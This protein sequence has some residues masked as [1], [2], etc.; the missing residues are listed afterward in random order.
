MPDTQTTRS[1]PFRARLYFDGQCPLCS[2]WAKRFQSR[3]ASK[4]V[5]LL[6]FPDDA[7]PEEMLLV[8]SHG[9]PC[10]GADAALEL[11]RL[12]PWL[13]PLHTASRLPGAKPVLRRLYRFIAARR[14]CHGAGCRISTRPAPRKS[15]ALLIGLIGL[16][17][18]VGGTLQPWQWMW[19][20]AAAMW[21]G[22][23]F[24]MLELAPAR[25][26]P[27]FFLWPG[28]DTAAFTYDPAA[29]R[30]ARPLYEPLLFL[31][32]GLLLIPLALSQT[33]PVVTGWLGFAAMLAL[34][35]F[36][37]FD[38]LGRFWNRLGYPVAPLMDQP[39][40]A[41]QPGEFWGQRWNRGYSDWARPILFRP[42]TRRFGLVGGI[43]GG[44]LVSGWAHELVISVPAGAGY[45]LPTLYFLIQGAG[46]LIARHPVVGKFLRTRPGTLFLVLA[47][48]PLLLHPPFLRHVFDPMIQ[49]LFS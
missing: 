2:R 7:H 10:G 47:P 24:M 16:A 21:L 5:R 22:F 13:R 44:F 27:W 48:S 32:T 49:T 1:G 28:M 12:F 45:G 25:V 43:M 23:K 26:S 34:L 37:L 30:P 11:C 17:W 19:V 36:G 46:V 33:N 20:L 3:L 4:G 18:M 35:H 6:P 42:L 31:A 39:W 41:R 40:K 9:H 14:Y 29:S 8:R 38:L 15:I